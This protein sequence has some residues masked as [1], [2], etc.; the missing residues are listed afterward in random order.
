MHF[1]RVWQQEIYY[2]AHLK[3]N[4][5]RCREPSDPLVV[6]ELL[7]LWAPVLTDLRHWELNKETYRSWQYKFL[8]VFRFDW[9]EIFNKPFFIYFDKF[10]KF[11]KQF[12]DVTF[13]KPAEHLFLERSDTWCWKKK[14]RS[15][16]WIL[17]LVQFL[18]KGSAQN[19]FCTNSQVGH[20]RS[21]SIFWGV[22]RFHH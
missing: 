10:H 6:K 11:V 19:R 18:P 5:F 12:R 9:K 8:N 20:R 16:R 15:L 13:C 7:P 2:P 22:W 14:T 4:E 21:G 17:K 1:C 3:G